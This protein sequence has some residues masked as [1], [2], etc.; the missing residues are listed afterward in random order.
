VVA[1]SL[2]AVEAVMLV[3]YGVLEIVAVSGSR[4]VM[5]V[6]TSAFFV[7]YGVALL[8]CVRGL[9][10]LRSWARAPIVLAQLIQVLVGWSFRGGGTTPVAVAM[11][12]VG[13]LVLAGLFHPASVR[14]LAPGSG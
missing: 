10:R 12:A 2:V 13:L 7:A 5:G 4:V 3:V 1:A 9:L 6:T 14:A 8:L 11:I